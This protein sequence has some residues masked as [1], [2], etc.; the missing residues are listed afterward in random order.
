MLTFHWVSFVMFH[1]LGQSI[2][3]PNVRCLPCKT[4]LVHIPDHKACKGCKASKKEAFDALTGLL[5]IIIEND[6]NSLN[7]E[8]DYVDYI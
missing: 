8:L 1:H 2:K 5:K 7:S 4:K 6:N 3:I